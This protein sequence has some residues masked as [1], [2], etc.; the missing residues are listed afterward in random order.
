MASD[1]KI[2][3]VDLLKKSTDWRWFESFVAA[4]G[5]ASQERFRRW[6]RLRTGGQWED[7]KEFLK[8]FRHDALHSIELADIEEVVGHRG[9][10]PTTH[11]LKGLT[12]AAHREFLDVS[13]FSPPF[14][15]EYLLHDCLERLGRVPRWNDVVFYLF[16]I[17]RDRY[18][19]PFMNKYHLIS[20]TPETKLG[21]PYFAT[22]Q[23]RTGNAYYSFLREIHLLTMLRQTYGLDVRYHVLA[24]VEFKADLIAGDTLVALYLPNKKYR[25]DRIGRK[26]K[27]SDANPNRKTIEVRIETHG[28][29][30]APWMTSP[31]SIRSLV[32]ILERDRCP[33]LLE[34]NEMA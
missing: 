4:G 23:W 9:R 26:L 24:D 13:D 10:H 27:I 19:V 8:S 14:A 6:D 7:V 3:K 1:V 11:A 32:D 5:Q 25:D 17:E 33:R 21:S 31:A 12:A 34:S 29:Y 2:S 28:G 20:G 18:I 30:G 22:L 16:N 15:I